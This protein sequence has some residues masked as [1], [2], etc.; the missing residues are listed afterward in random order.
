[1]PAARL[2][3]IA[4]AVATRLASLTLM[5]GLPLSAVSFAIK[6]FYTRFSGLL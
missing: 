1:M 3:R 5:A 4:D 2:F 6:K